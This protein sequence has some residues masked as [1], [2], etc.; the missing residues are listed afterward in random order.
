MKEYFSIK[1]SEKKEMIEKIKGV[2]FQEKSIVFAFLFGSFLDQP[3]FR[4][5]DIGIYVKN[6]KKNEIFNYE[7]E[8]SKKLAE[9]CEL[10][11]DVFEVKILNFSPNPFLNNIF[12]RGRLLFSKDE[13]FLTDMIENTSLDT[14]A[15]EYIAQQSLRE[16]IPT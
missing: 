7:L 6:I 10:S 15:N 11:F 8:L 1:P 14:I 16:L 3:S 2:L 5:I 9:K 12:S 13:K 4:D